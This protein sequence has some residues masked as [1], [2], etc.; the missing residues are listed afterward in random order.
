MADL[1]K[2][3][4][5]VNWFITFILKC[6]EIIEWSTGKRHHHVQHSWV[7]SNLWQQDVWIL[8]KDRVT[9]AL[10]KNVWNVYVKQFLGAL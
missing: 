1:V 8:K 7:V 3:A 9:L 2:K 10:E 6:K 4:Q 5:C